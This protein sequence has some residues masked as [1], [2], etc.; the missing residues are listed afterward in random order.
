MSSSGVDLVSRSEAREC[1]W[2]DDDDR[3]CLWVGWADV[4]Y[5]R[6]DRSVWWVCPAC[7]TEHEERW[8]DE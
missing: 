3:E 1:W 8:P 7:E 5:D 2:L 6:E 4:S